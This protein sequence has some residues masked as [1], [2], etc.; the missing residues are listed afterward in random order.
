MHPLQN[1]YSLERTAVVSRPSVL[2]VDDEPDLLTLLEMT[3]ARMDI[4]AVTASSL[5]AAREALEAA[6]PALCLTDLRLPDG[7]GLDLIAEIQQRYPSVPVAM[8]TAH[9]STE[10]AVE[11]LKLGAFDFV[12]KPVPID[13][14]RELV[15]H[16]LKLSTMP[17]AQTDDTLIGETP[18]IATLKRDIQRV[19]RSQAPVHVHG[20]SGVGKEVVARLVHQLGPRSAAPF[21][22]INC[23]AIPSELVESELFGHKR[24]AFTGATSD[25]PGLFQAASG[26]TLLLDEIADLPLSVQVKLLRAIQEKA[27]R[28]LGVEKEVPVDVRLITATHKNLA[29]EVREGR[30]RDDL[31]YRINV[32]DLFIPPLRHRRADIPLIARHILLK[33]ADAAHSKP[34]SLSSDA[35]ELL[36]QHEFRGNIRELENI[37]ARAAALL[38]GD[39]IERHNLDLSPGPRQTAPQ[40]AALIPEISQAPPAQEHHHLGDLDSYLARVE[41]EILEDTLQRHRWNRAATAKALGIN[42]RSLRYRL[43]K[44]DIEV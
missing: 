15:N 34:L 8:M 17:D 43:K 31:Y 28:P 27:V 37:L 9:G 10:S 40:D 41:R 5:A 3:L 42:L 13:R 16:A 4:Q 36:K 29:E 35:I 25:K 38:D 32:I 22:A 26:G 24:G 33:M 11:A 6:T 19:A 39:R 1:E 23:G 44:L 30:F 7:N 14:L 2:I 18:I 20:E 21:L 12:S